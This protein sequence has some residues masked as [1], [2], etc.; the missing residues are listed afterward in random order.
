MAACRRTL[1]GYEAAIK[2]N[3]RRD[4]RH[5]IEHIE[6]I[7]PADIPRLKELGVIASLQP[8][9]GVGVPGN[10]PEPILSRVGE[11]SC[12]MPMPGRRCAR[13]AR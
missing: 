12:P 13:R 2:A 3:G 11:R 8:I 5:R 6:M 1:D 10:P 7:D 4:S 9:A